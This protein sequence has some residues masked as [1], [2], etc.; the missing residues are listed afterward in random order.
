MHWSVE[1]KCSL[2][3]VHLNATVNGVTRKIAVGGTFDRL[4][5]GHKKLLSLAAMLCAEFSGTL[6]VGVTDDAL[7][8]HKVRNKKSV[9]IC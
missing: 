1:Y 8:G 7:V 9:L 6:V 3:Y 5:V 4:H 2:A